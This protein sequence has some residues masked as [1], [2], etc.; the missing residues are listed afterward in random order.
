MIKSRR[1]RWS[2]HVAKMEIANFN[3]K[4]TFRKERTILE[5]ILNKYLSKRG[6]RLIWLRIGMIGEPLWM[7]HW[8]S[9]FYKP[10]RL[11]HCPDY[12]IMTCRALRDIVIHSPHIYKNSV[13]WIDIAMQAGLHENI[14]MQIPEESVTWNMLQCIAELLCS[15]HFNNTLWNECLFNAL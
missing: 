7:Q 12:I 3:R 13:K 2:G 4:E 6:I 8:T 10:W 14:N 9:G 15:L 1:L 5:W 11:T